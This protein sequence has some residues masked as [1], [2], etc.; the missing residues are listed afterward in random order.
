MYDCKLKN[1]LIFDKNFYF[2]L[3]AVKYKVKYSKEN[4][5]D[6]IDKYCHHLDRCEDS[7]LGYINGRVNI[8]L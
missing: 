3:Y 8:L 5:D 2:A 1:I 6:W 4:V 7:V